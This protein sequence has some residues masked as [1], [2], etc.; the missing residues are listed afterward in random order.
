MPLFPALRDQPDLQQQV[1]E[2][3]AKSIQRDCLKDF[4]HHISYIS[5]F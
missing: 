4:R 3:V 2:T 5:S 1:P